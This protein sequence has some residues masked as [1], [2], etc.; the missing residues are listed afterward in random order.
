MG[1]AAADRGQERPGDGASPG[2]SPAR[3][4]HPGAAGGTAGGR[5]GQ[6]GWYRGKGRWPVSSLRASA[7]AARTRTRGRAPTMPDDTTVSRPFAPLPGRPDLP[8]IEHEMLDRWQQGKVFERSLE[9]TAGGPR[10]TFYEGPPTANGAPGVHHVEARVFK[11]VFPR[12]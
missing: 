8:A 9:Q 7:Q 11:E 6:G 2:A 3:P 12:V 1:T 10:W 5:T 4:D